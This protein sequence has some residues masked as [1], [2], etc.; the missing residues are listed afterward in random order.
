MT[1]TTT[2][3]VGVGQ[4]GRPIVENLL[5]D[6]FS[7]TVYDP[8]P[9]AVAAAVEAGATSSDSLAEVGADA[10]MVFIVVPTDNQVQDVCLGTNGL[11][12]GMTEGD[13]VMNSSTYPSLPAK[14]QREAPNGVSVV[15]APMCRGVAAAEQGEILFLV[16]GATDA[17]E[18]CRPML[19]A[20]GEVTVLGGP[21]AGQVGKTANNLLLWITILG[22][23]EALRLAD[24]LD[25]DIDPVELRSI[26]PK[27]SGDNW[28][29]REGNWE[30]L[31]LAWPEKDLAIALDLAD[32]A[33]SPIPISG[34]ASQLIKDLDVADL[35]QYYF[36]TD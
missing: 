25:V 10:D 18:R 34:L 20:C 14:L 4:M 17:I 16:G 6:D 28:A 36:D 1:D 32:T 31:Q 9:D 12:D 35:E 27:S 11:F 29:I 30:G 15:D 19:E 22:D 24:R 8:D 21:G 2:G 13:I 7:V 23:Y 26:L 33:D 5:T 3:V